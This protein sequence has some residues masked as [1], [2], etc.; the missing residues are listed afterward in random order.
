[1]LLLS[2]PTPSLC[3]ETS[4]QPEKLHWEM[5]EGI[6]PVIQ[7]PVFPLRVAVIIEL[8]AMRPAV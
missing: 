7:V 1:M 3:L 6:A 8:R 5:V 4:C 2:H